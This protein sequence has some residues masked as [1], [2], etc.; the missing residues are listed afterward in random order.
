VSKKVLKKPICLV[1]QSIWLLVLHTTL[2]VYMPCK[3]IAKAWI[4]QVEFIS[5]AQSQVEAQTLAKSK[6][7][8]MTWHFSKTRA[9]TIHYYM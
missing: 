5:F 4:F 9:S 8:F 6:Y 1:V 3:L 7:T 2:L